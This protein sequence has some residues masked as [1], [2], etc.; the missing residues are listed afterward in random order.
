[1]VAALVVNLLVVQAGINM[2]YSAILLPQLSLPNSSIT[3][4]KA[5][6]SWIGKFIYQ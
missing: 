5:E 4:T 2:A 6:G 3:I 1:M